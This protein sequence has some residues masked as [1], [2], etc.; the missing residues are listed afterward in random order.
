MYPNLSF[1]DSTAALG[2]W[3]RLFIVP[4]AAHCSTNSL[5]PNGPFPQTNLAVLIDWVENGVKPETLNATILNG[6]SKGSNQQ[7][8]AWPLRPLWT[9]GGNGTGIGLGMDCVYD[10]KSIDTWLY[11]LDAW[12]M[13]V[14]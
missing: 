11:D 5:Q 12:K 9:Q 7:I 8:C 13:P 2:D 3:Y 4:G 6:D 1:N 10:Q 14:Y